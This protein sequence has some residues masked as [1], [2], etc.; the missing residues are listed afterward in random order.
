MPT[1]MFFAGSI[2]NHPATFFAIPSM[3]HVTWDRRQQYMV[4]GVCVES[5]RSVFDIPRLRQL[6]VVGNGKRLLM[7]AGPRQAG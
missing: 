2:S 7:V 4:C 5:L 6:N 1:F 3:A